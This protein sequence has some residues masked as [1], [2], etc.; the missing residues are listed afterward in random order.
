MLYEQVLQPALVAIRENWGTVSPRKLALFDWLLL[1]A[2]FM[3]IHYLVA[4]T[5][6]LPFSLF[7][8]LVL[9][10]GVWFV[11][12]IFEHKF[13]LRH[14]HS[15]P[16]LALRLFHATLLML[17]AVALTLVVAG[18]GSFN[19]FF[20]L[21]TF[22][23]LLSLELIILA[24]YATRLQLIAGKAP[25]K[26]NVRTRY[27]W[28][29]SMVVFDFILYLALIFIVHFIKYGHLDLEFRHWR[30]LLIMLGMW[31]FS[32]KWTGKF[33]QRDHLN[34]HHAYEPFIKAAFILAAASALLFYSFQIYQF[35]RTI[36]LLPVV[37]L[38]VLE[39]PAV[40]KW[41]KSG[42]L[43]ALS[44]SGD[45]EKIEQVHRFF[46][47]SEQEDDV[48]S[49]SA[50]NA[51]SQ[52][53]EFYLKNHP[54]LFEFIDQRCDLRKIPLKRLEV[55]DTHT[56]YNVRM[57]ENSS[58][59]IFINLHRVNDFR[60]INYYFLEAHQKL[61]P[62]GYFVGLMDTIESTM[63]R[64]KHK[65]PKYMAWTLYSLDFL[66]RRVMPKI[67]GL[68][69]IYFTL[70]G[71][72]NRL[73]SKAELLGR[74]YFCGFRVLSA[75]YVG[76]QFFFLAQKD[77]EPD[78][79][80]DPTYGLLIKLKRVGFQR[81]PIYLYKLRTMHPYSEF[82]QEYIYQNHQ[83]D[84]GG[85]FRDDFRVASWGKVFRQLWLDEL[86][87]LINW[88]RGD[89]K[90]VGARALSEHYFS[91]YPKDL[92]TLRSQFKPG[93]VPPYYADMP[94]TMEE[95]QESERHYFAAKLAH[96]IWAD[97]RYFFRAMCNIVFR[98]ARSK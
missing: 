7:Q 24:S 65:F 67:P 17:F 53:M 41:N 61:A 52:L 15:A 54:A 6:R 28:A 26:S 68:Q 13:S 27:P 80:H 90:L 91:L 29:M 89:V 58:L 82:I 3:I 86:P 12:S 39:I 23:G 62:D 2:L 92:Q 32:A 45:I 11:I 59:R 63:V 14:F 33:E 36:L 96:P 60:R 25:V 69:K 55:L 50:R 21:G 44:P 77:R 88:L 8:L 97:W 71:G 81:K 34:F 94:K 74:L 37:L 95:I 78:Q 38:L 49:P 85:K 1:N 87:Q 9:I 51:R 84:E 35:C 57:L 47:D 93:L 22:A 40:R 75:E 98:H 56:A 18:A 4:G 73:F 16:E 79:V 70:S 66:F 30:L 5:L 42:K 72:R 10:N 19:R 46:N 20:I 48:A 43:K 64:L 31:A 76:T 83:I